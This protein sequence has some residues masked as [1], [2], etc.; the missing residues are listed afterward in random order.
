M[1]K[2]VRSLA[3]LALLAALVAGC[4]GGSSGDATDGGDDTA[5]RDTA[6][7]TVDPATLRDGGAAT[8]A[9][10]QGIGQLDPYKILYSFESVAHTMLFSPLTQYTIDGGN[11]VQPGLA[12]SWKPS[13]D[14]RTWTFELR[15]GMKLSNG[16]PLDARVVAASL[17]RAFD[18]RTVFLWVAFLP[19]VRAIE[20]TGATTVRIALAR[21][22][23]N[24]PE[25]M[26]KIP[27]EDVAT[28]DRID[29][30]PVVTGPYK[31]SRFTP[32]QEL[33]MVPNEHY[34]GP[35]PH[36]AE[37]TIAKA[38][39]NT[40]ASTSLRAGEIQ[41]LWS[42]PWTDVRQLADAG[43]GDVVVTTGDEPVQNM[44]LMTD[45]Q[46]GVFR[47]VK[48][49][50]ALAHAIDREA[51]LKA[52][53]AG[54]GIVPVGNDPLPAWSELA[55]KGLPPY[56]FDLDK[57]KELFAQA[58][59]GPD[60]PLT[61][62]APAGQYSE[63]T[64]VGEVLQSDLEQIGIPMKIETNEISQFAARFA[65]AGKSWPNLIVPNIYG[66]L[67]VELI[68]D[69]WAPGVC[70]CNF[71]DP[72]YNK[73]LA[74]AQAAPDEA[75]FRAAMDRAQEVF[76]AQAP[77][78]VVV[79]TSVPVGHVAALKNVWIDPTGDARFADAGYAE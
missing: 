3:L 46:H 71:D 66:G 79:H 74:D 13:G 41:A 21:P 58:G 2:M 33:V 11:E 59:I 47:D 35:A 30:E 31:V 50:R 61:F 10:A 24:L 9:A 62:W 48:A 36:L 23:R 4:G 44:I 45:N 19:S 72:Q 6:N 60:T 54:R 1:R 76:N 67:P 43:R 8:I 38:Q 32:D 39:D 49:R 73:A 34:Y 77:S 52:I 17:E 57:A 65:P 53:Y 16:K 28:L 63:W 22:A 5:V 25:A 42:I 14:F 68:P 27:I 56:E 70:E 26:T 7:A 18:P 55:A 78:A 40:A 75:A 64:S 15:P 20:A 29:R 51:I 12:K 69:W 37:V